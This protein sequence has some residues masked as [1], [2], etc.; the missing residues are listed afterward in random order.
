[1]SFAQ[2]NLCVSVTLLYLDEVQS[3]SMNALPLGTWIS[4]AN[5]LQL[6]RPHQSVMVLYS[7]EVN[8]K[9]VD[10]CILQKCLFR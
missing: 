2:L 1:M 5:A 7:K 4:M 8:E 3:R 10:I 9:F 6:L